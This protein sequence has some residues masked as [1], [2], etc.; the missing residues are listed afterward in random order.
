VQFVKTYL[1]ILLIIVER[2]LWSRQPVVFTLEL[3]GFHAKI[4]VFF[5]CD[6]CCHFIVVDP[7]KLLQV[8]GN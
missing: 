3:R 2:F 7:H 5:D 8:R 4:G 6:Y 1:Y